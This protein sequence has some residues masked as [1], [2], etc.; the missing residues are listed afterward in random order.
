MFKMLNSMLPHQSTLPSGF[1]VDQERGVREIGLWVSVLLSGLSLFQ[2]VLGD[3]VLARLGILGL[4][5]AGHGAGLV[6]LRRSS[7]QAAVVCMGAGGWAAAALA[8]WLTGGVGSA[9]LGAAVLILLLIGLMGGVRLL[10]IFTALSVANLV[11]MWCAAAYGWLPERT[12]EV[13]GS[14]RFV[15]AAGLLLMCYAGIAIVVNRAQEEREQS[16]SERERADLSVKSFETL[17]IKSPAPM[18]LSEARPRPGEDTRKTIVFN[19]AFRSLF[20]TEAVSDTSV[21]TA[22]LW[23]LPEELDG[24]RDKILTTGS[25][26]LT[27]CAMRSRKGRNLSC[28]VGAAPVRWNDQDAMLWMFQDVTEIETLRSSLEGVN[29]DLELRVA[30]KAKEL[31][32][33]Q[34][35]L[36]RRERLA[37][38][39]EMV[40]GVAHEINTPLGNALL[41]GSSAIDPVRRIESLGAG[42]MVSRAEL[43]KSAAR[44]RE[45]LEVTLSNLKRASE[46]IENFKRLSADQAGQTRRGFDL[47]DVLSS[48][49]K[50]SGPALAA[51]G[52]S[53]RVESDPSAAGLRV[54]GYPGAVTQIATA[55]AANAVIHAFASARAGA[56][57]GLLLARVTTE[58]CSSGM[59][60]VE[61][62]D[63]GPGM[64]A[65]VAA[66]VFEPFFTTKM[67]QGGTGL[68]LAISWNLASEALGGAITARRSLELGGACFDLDLALVSPV[69]E[70]SSMH[71]PE[72]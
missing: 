20:G 24:L 28:Y 9:S 31:A 54:E 53:W 60:R 51:C 41:A 45:A 13:A 1:G 72:A 21:D 50:M 5:L 62:H 69:A 59:A 4:W 18:S 57:Q 39:G 46:I 35:E 25:C 19:E 56:E 37:N 22:K 47:A 16:L 3:P 2:I 23:L 33:A 68:G 8:Q 64:S 40:A 58:G 34:K 61:F 7:L 10:M 42:Q 27:Q 43:L 17:F 36:A 49:L 70:L 63:N 15:Q 29:S 26:E 14:L 48:A 67:G 32:L 12:L 44:A 71:R 38:L 11:A 30:T 66:R 6:A 65:E 55:L 52:A